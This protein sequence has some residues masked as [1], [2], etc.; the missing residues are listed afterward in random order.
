MWS[1]FKVNEMTVAK[2]RNNFA[3]IEEICYAG[4]GADRNN[5]LFTSM[6]CN[7]SEIFLGPPD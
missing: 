4:S 6:E 1:L 2:R 7:F 5:V 3:C